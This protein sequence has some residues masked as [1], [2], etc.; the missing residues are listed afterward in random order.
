MKEYYRAGDR[1]ASNIHGYYYG[2]AGRIVKP[3]QVQYGNFRRFIVELDNGQRIT[4][5]VNHIKDLPDEKKGTG[6]NEY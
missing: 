3:A 1:V 2:L 4:L 6:N 5:A